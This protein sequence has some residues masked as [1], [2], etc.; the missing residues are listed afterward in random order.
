VAVTFGML[1]LEEDVG[2]AEV[3]MAGSFQ[4]AFGKWM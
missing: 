1:V 2:T 3:E 4:K